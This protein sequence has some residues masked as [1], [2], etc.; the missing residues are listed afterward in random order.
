MVDQVLRIKK[1]SSINLDDPFFDSL[2]SDYK[3]FPDWFSKKADASAFVFENSTGTGLEGFMYLK[4]E[5]GPITDVAPPLQP[6]HRVKIGT[7]KINPHGTRLGERFLKRAVDY[8]IDI[9]ATS[10][11]VTVFSKH[12]ALLDLFLKYGFREVA[13]KPSTNGTEAVF[14]RNLLH[15]VGDV[16]LD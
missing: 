6:A 2:K 16:V 8:A 11:Y 4:T 7:F 13:T 1:F 5:S 12:T 9:A 10:M 14:E 3:E 15:T